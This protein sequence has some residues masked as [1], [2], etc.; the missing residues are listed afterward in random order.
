MVRDSIGE[1]GGRSDQPGRSKWNGRRPPSSQR[2]VHAVAERGAT[3][4]RGYWYVLPA[5][6]TDGRTVS[7]ELITPIC[8]AS[9]GSRR[10]GTV[11]SAPGINGDPRGRL[12]GRGRAHRHSVGAGRLPT[13]RL[14][15]GYNKSTRSLMEMKMHDPCVR[16]CLRS[17]RRSLIELSSR[18][19][20]TTPYCLHMR[21]VERQRQREARTRAPRTHVRTYNYKK[22]TVGALMWTFMATMLLL[23]LWSGRGFAACMAENSTACIVPC[24]CSAVQAAR[25]RFDQRVW[26]YHALCRH[27][28]RRYSSYDSSFLTLFLRM[29]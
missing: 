24:P 6:W 29:K 5:A 18:R 25:S 21:P 13:R 28:D 12:V 27:R 7:L 17:M 14:T 8:C 1:N 3:S 4:G 19:R 2:Y 22:A 16:A 26:W 11:L 15:Y 20:S 10:T 23:C 9:R